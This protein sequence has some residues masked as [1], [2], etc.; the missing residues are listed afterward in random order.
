[1]A[2]EIAGMAGQKLFSYLTTFSDEDKTAF[3]TNVA[4]TAFSALVSERMRSRDD[5]VYLGGGR[6]LNREV[7]RYE[8]NIISRSQFLQFSENYDNDKL[9]WA[10]ELKQKDRVIEEGGNSIAIF[11]DDKNSRVVFVSRFELFCDDNINPVSDKD[12]KKFKDVLE[13]LERT[14]EK[15]IEFLDKFKRM[16]FNVV[17][18]EIC[19]KL[20]LPFVKK[21]S[22]G[23]VVAWI[24]DKQ[25]DRTKEYTSAILDN[26]SDSANLALVLKS[27]NTKPGIVFANTLHRG[28]TVLAAALACRLVYNDEDKTD[29]DYNTDK[30]RVRDESEEFC[31]RILDELV[32]QEGC[33]DKEILRNY[34]FEPPL[35]CKK[36][37]LRSL[38]TSRTTRTR[39][40]KNS[41]KETLQN[42][43][44]EF[45]RIVGRSREFNSGLVDAA[46]MT[47]LPVELSK[48]ASLDSEMMVA[49]GYFEKS[50]PPETFPRSIFLELFRD[51]RDTR[52]YVVRMSLSEEKTA[53]GA[54]ESPQVVKEVLDLLEKIFGELEQSVVEPKELFVSFLKKIADDND[55][56]GRFTFQFVGSE[57]TLVENMVAASGEKFLLDEIA[58]WENP[59][60]SGSST[61]RVFA[62]NAKPF[63]E[64]CKDK[65]NQTVLSGLLQCKDAT[66]KNFARELLLTFARR[67]DSGLVVDQP[68][69][70]LGSEEIVRLRDL[71][72]SKKLS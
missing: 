59:Q 51:Q 21:L 40:C 36:R 28:T 29:D 13:K 27:M 46:T 14:W 5:K 38:M 20:V 45:D 47:K 9:E 53:A 71:V 11:S 61:T 50:A 4:T 65:K 12:R 70:D 69:I 57:K 3:A 15:L 22:N 55:G 26:I 10:K 23:G 16:L 25:I 43:V 17:T 7:V 58:K 8:D 68:V 72:K 64:L 6:E 39:N 63:A 19:M 24:N 48:S 33:P 54:R 41:E 42:L 18:R 60:T 49:S 32:F 67:D 52:R 2:N 56:T 1:M 62:I 44:N 34:V 37:G 35:F 31:V 30:Q 66:L